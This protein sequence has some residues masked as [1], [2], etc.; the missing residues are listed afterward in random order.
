M[1][2]ITLPYEAS[3]AA[4][5]NL[6]STS[7][8]GLIFTYTLGLLE[9]AQSST[10]TTQLAGQGQLSNIDVRKLIGTQTVGVTNAAGLVQNELVVGAGWKN[11]SIEQQINV[12]QENALGWFDI[13]ETIEHNVASNTMTA[14]KMALRHALLS[15]IGVAPYGAEVLFSPLLNCYIYDPKEAQRGTNFQYLRLESLHIQSNRIGF[16]SGSTVMENVTFRPN[17]IHRVDNDL[18]EGLMRKL[19]QLFPGM[20]E[21]LEKIQDTFSYNV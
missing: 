16:N 9:G 13:V 10:Q 20:Y 11:V 19:R 18:P 3:K 14:D 5:Q 12:T 1:T 4:Q 2:K 7:R 6:I 17:R 21:D 8:V 15:K